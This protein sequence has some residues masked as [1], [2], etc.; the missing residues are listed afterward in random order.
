M[1]EVDGVGVD[2]MLPARGLHNAVDATAAFAMARA[3]LGD[4]FD[5]AAA[6]AARASARWPRSTGAGSPPAGEG[7]SCS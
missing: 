7:S 6:A 2:V 5:L 4:G 3:L 1:I